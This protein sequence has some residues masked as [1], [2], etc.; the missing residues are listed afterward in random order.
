MRRFLATV[1]AVAGLSVAA[2][3][4]IAGEGA[5]KPAQSVAPS[6]SGYGGGCHDEYPTQTVK[7]A[8]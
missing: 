5:K 2:A 3:P 7:P 1:F 6:Q 4:V 8:A